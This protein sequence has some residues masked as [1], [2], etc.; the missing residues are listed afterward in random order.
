MSILP[1]SGGRGLYPRVTVRGG[2]GGG[3]FSICS[4]SL[5]L[6]PDGRL[7]TLSGSCRLGSR[8]EL[9]LLLLLGW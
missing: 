5:D 2:A 7:D 1:P 6:S 4:R 9:V 3:T 8:G